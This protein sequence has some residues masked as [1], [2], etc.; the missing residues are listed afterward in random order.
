MNFVPK[1]KFDDS[2]GNTISLPV[3]E[4]FIDGHFVKRGRCASI[5]D[6]YI[7]V[8]DSPRSFDIYHN[9]ILSRNPMFDTLWHQLSERKVV[10]E[11]ANAYKCVIHMVRA[12]PFLVQRRHS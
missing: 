6:F 3:D 7:S 1:V 10:K 4:D 5:K 12:H 11:V 2:F 9:W 8:V